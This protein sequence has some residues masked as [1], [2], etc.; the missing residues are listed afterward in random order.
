MRTLTSAVDVAAADH[1]AN[2]AAMLA[3][4]AEIDALNLQVMAGGSERSVATLRSRGKLLP[5]ERIDLLLDQDSPFL[6]LSALAGHGTGD[7]LGGGVVTG[8]GLVQG[9]ECL[10]VANDPTVK[11]GA[12]SPTSVAKVLRS[13]EIARVNRLPLINLTE[14]AGADL[15]R[16]SEIFVPGG[17]AFKNLTQLSAAGIPTVALVFGSSTAG[18]AYVP[19]MSDYTVLQAGAARVY[20]GGPPLVKM[21]T[22]EDADEE[23]LGGAAMHARVS[24]LADYLGADEPDT[25]RIGR[26]IVGHLRWRKLGPIPVEAAPS[27]P[28]TTRTSSWASSRR[29]CGSRS[30]YARSSPGWSTAAASRSSSRS[31]DRPW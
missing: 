21:A 29:T 30:R 20:L 8:I 11:G 23:E 26:D 17:A 5:R 7:P 3:A 27:C 9:V 19:G 31:T 25:I 28:P 6:E 14:S 2:R 13:M 16:Q 22:D 15:T 18:G 1:L 12:Q 24:G 4:L 10:V